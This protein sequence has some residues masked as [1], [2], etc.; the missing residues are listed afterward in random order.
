[1]T[2]WKTEDV[3]VQLVYTR[4]TFG[5]YGLFWQHWVVEDDNSNSQL[6]SQIVWNPQYVGRDLQGV[7]LWQLVLC[8]VTTWLLILHSNTL[9]NCIA[10]IVSSILGVG[11]NTSWP[12]QF[13]GQRC[14]ILDATCAESLANFKQLLYCKDISPVVNIV[15]QR[16]ETIGVNLVY[17]ATKKQKWQWSKVHISTIS[18]AQVSR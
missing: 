8:F 6:V 7:P 16:K 3:F 12:S 9:Y 2:V 5:L 14:V 13:S 18:M 4:N 17:Q 10:N 11:Q 15:C 1:M